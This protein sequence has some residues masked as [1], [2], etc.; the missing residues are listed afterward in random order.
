MT[1]DDATA[2]RGQVVTLIDDPFVVS[3]TDAIQFWS[4]GVVVM[5]DGLIEAV[6]A[7]DDVLPAWPGISVE[8]FA[9]DLIL[10][11]FVDCHVHYPQLGV[12]ASYGARLFDWLNT[13]TFPEELKFSDPQY[14]STIAER[15]LDELARN[16]TTSACVY[17]TV[18]S[19]SVTALF[20]AAEARGIRIATGKMMMD[21]NAPPDLTDTVQ[22]SYDESIALAGMWHGRGRLTYAVSPRFAPTSTP[23]QLEAAGA[24]W[25]AYPDALLQT[26]MSEQ[27]DELKTVADLFPSTRDYLDVYESAGLARP[28]ANFGHAVHLTDRECDALRGAGAGISHCPTS[29][30]FLGSGL[31]DLA[32][33]RNGTDAVPVGLGTDVGGGTSFSMLATMQDA[34]KIAQLRDTS[35][36]PIC[37]FYLATVGSAAVMR[38][39]DKVGNLERGREADLIV[40][41]PKA[42]PVLA[43]RCGRVETIS[44]VLFA[45]MILGDDRV[46]KRT[47]SA[48]KTLYARDAAA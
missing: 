10:P 12:I 21:R 18:H 19:A 9:D 8:R 24:V 28:G 42:T 48:G 11:G 32:G 41:D 17:A 38:M 1:S 36:H 30:L 35:L 33:L 31:F 6:G 22:S 13:Y 15:F 44:D 46:V 20:E 29:N 5:R 47:V 3:P 27:T 39:T 25:D 2:V 4:D 34:Y 26:H 16:G 45:L 43:E 23:E 7:A 40:L 37:A 14:A